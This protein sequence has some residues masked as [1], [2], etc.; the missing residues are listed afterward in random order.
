MT[1]INKWVILDNAEKAPSWHKPVLSHGDTRRNFG[2]RIGRNFCR[3][4]HGVNVGVFYYEVVYNHNGFDSGC[5][6]VCFT[7]LQPGLMGSFLPTNPTVN[8]PPLA[9]NYLSH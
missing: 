8:W 6:R 7:V 5:L 4:W 1:G 3:P 9:A 2:G